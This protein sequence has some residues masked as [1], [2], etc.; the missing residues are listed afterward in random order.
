[1]LTT[2][3]LAINLSFSSPVRHELSLAGN[4][5][6]PRPHHFHGGIDVRTDG[7]EKKAVLSVADGY[8]SRVTTGLLGFG[9]AVYITH[10][11]GVTTVYAHLHSFSSR[12][13]ELVKRYRYKHECSLTTDAHFAP[14]ECPV[15]E[16]QFIAFSGNTGSSTAPHL[17]LEFHDT[18]T[19]KMLDPL[20][21]L[22]E[23]VSDSVPP[24]AHG[25]MAYPQYGKGV[26]CGGSAK[27]NYG[28][29]SNT[30][31]RHFTAWGK[32]GFAIWADDYTQTAYNHL[33]V[34]NTR[35]LCDGKEVFSSTVD[36][37]PIYSNRQINIWGD[38]E[39]FRRTRV[40]YLKSFIEPGCRLYFMRADENR[41]II[42]FNEER[43]YTLEYILKDHKGNES[44][45]TFFVEGTP[46]PLPKSVK[47]NSRQTM[48]CNITSQYSL[49]GMQ[50]VIPSGMIGN[51]IVLHPVTTPCEEDMLSAKYSFY[52]KSCPLVN[53]VEL[54]IYVK[55]EV[56]DPSKLYIRSNM[57]KYLGGEYKNGWV[58]CGIRELG[59]AYEVAYDDEKPIIN[60]VGEPESWTST[61]TIRLALSDKESGLKEYKVCID[62]RFVYFAPQEKSNVV[63]CRLKDTP[64]KKTGKSHR[65]TVSATDNRNNTATYTT[66][67]TW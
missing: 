45:Y 35:L 67:F 23:F 37:I 24:M 64:V 41:G 38:Y 43:T 30:M 6:E 63:L 10:P 8:V 7:V 28:F 65:L 58:T 19:W 39:H 26:F 29:T 22:S 42:D 36:S 61:G 2:L 34:R 51:D 57:R 48:R 59:N 27:Q 3:L 20:N 17:H 25:F 32:V 66:R 50:L 14:W 47:K 55:Q 56:K 1:M 54:G 44:S 16:G 33:G 12:I 49:P 9:N 52:D 11:N 31:E 21:Y 15:S 18:K 5:G 13:E 46:T 62:G 40:W 60:T 53:D 4:F